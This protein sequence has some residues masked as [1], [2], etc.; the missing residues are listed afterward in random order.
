MKTF[1]LAWITS[2]LLLFD[3]S[4]ISNAQPNNLRFENLSGRRGLPKIGINTIL[5]DQEGFM[6]F[7]TNEGL[8]RFDGHTATVFQHDPNDP[9]HSLPTNL[10]IN[11]HEDRK[12]RFWVA[13]PV[14][15][16]L[17]DKR[18]G[19]ATT[20]RPDSS[21]AF[22][23]NVIN[24]ILE[25][26]EG[27]LWLGT[28]KGIVRF[29][30]STLKFR[31]YSPPSQQ[32]PYGLN[33]DTAG[34]LWSVI[35]G[36]LCR[37]D[38]PT[39]KFD[40]YK[41]K[42]Q[43]GRKSGAFSLYI[44]ATGIAWVGTFG[45]G[46]FRMDTRTPGR[47]VP[48]NPRGI[49]FKI[50]NEIYEADGYLWLASSGLQ[51][52]NPK[53]NEVINYHSDNFQSGT[54]SNSGVYTSYQDRW[55]NLWVG[56]TSGVNK[57]SVRTSPFYT[58]QITPTPDAFIRPEN[59]VHNVLEDRT[60]T[61]WVGNQKG[62]CRFDPSTKQMTQVTVNPADSRNTLE[63]QQWPLLEDRRGRL[64]V[65]TDLDQGLYVLDRTTNKFTR[66]NSKIAIRRL[67]IAP[68][69]TIW[70][71]SPVNGI[72]AFDPAREK[73]TYYPPTD[74]VDGVPL[75]TY[76]SAILVSRSE[77]VWVA[78]L[79]TGLIRLNPKTGKFTQY[80]PNTQM[81]Q[82]GLLN[83]LVAIS[84]YE[85][86]AGI[87]WIG[88]AE[89]GLNRLDPTTNVFTYFTTR[90]GLPSNAINSITGDKRGNLWLGT[91]QGLSR[92]N[93]NNHTCR[94]FDESDGL[95][96]DFFI[97]GSIYHNNGKLFLGTR[98]G[99]VIFR[100]DSIKEI[101]ST[102]AYITA[103]KVGERYIPLSTEEIELSH[104]ENYLSFDFTAVN[105]DSPEKTRYAYQ[106]EGV[107][108]DWVYTGNRRS[109]NYAYL[110][111]GSYTFRVKASTNNKVWNDAEATIKIRIHPPWWQTWWAYS[112]YGLLGISVLFGLIRYN[113][114]RERLKS[115]LKIQRLEA[116]KMHEIDHLKS[117]FFANISHE[118]RTP[119]T[120]ILG[121]LEKFLSRPST[122]DD[123]KSAYRMMQRN[124]QR[125]L[126][127]INQLLDLS[128]LETGSMKLETKPASLA[129]FLKTLVSSFTSLA[130]TRQIQYHFKYFTGNPTVYFD[131]D[132]L[133]KIITNLL[134]NAFKFT[135][136]GGSISISALLLKREHD[137]QAVSR[138]G[139][140]SLTT[141]E[142]KVQDSGL[143][144]PDD[145][146]D[147]IFNRFYQTDTSQ[148]QAK[149]G[150]GIGL[151]LVRELVE[152][153]GGKVM[154]ESQVG[155]GTRFTIHLPLN[156]TDFEETIV[157]HGP[158]DDRNNEER[159]KITFEN[160]SSD[161]NDL[162][163]LATE[164]GSVDEPIILI[165]EDNTD[166]RNF[167]REN[168]HSY[169][170]IEAEE[171]E[172]A[173]KMASETIPDLIISDVMM[174]KMN[175]VE[176]CSKL[177]GNEKTDHI[178]VILL[179]AKASVENKIEGLETG[180][181]DYIVKPF[182]MSELLIRIKNLLES[183][184]KLRE[185][186]SREIT[187]Q[188]ASISITPLDEKLL[189]RVMEIME[190][191]ISD[192][193]FGVELFCQEAA[194]SR[195]QLYRKLKALT[196]QSPSDFIRSMRLKRAAELIIHNAGNIAEVAFQ[197]GFK[198]PSYFT[199]CFQMQFG[200]TPSEFAKTASQRH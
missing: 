20:Y 124:A 145:Q 165:V 66:Y 11:I 63:G 126:H 84:V 195:V 119:L 15:L 73:F 153:H 133:E 105:F 86:E 192:S 89:G 107:D 196:D 64:W 132:K 141:L 114:S 111:P 27:L 44:D 180:A 2:S 193:N 144:I 45:D 71:G 168:L 29:D 127:L 135:S 190:E 93:P 199:K 30:P 10:I 115:D 150:T 81:K 16:L 125:L 32:S 186:F 117:R 164:M 77:E 101:L 148:K 41:I 12:G 34:G 160:D 36:G 122:P 159:N 104:Q 161:L 131:A 37:F 187:L 51:R 6:W 33:Q 185:R 174:P 109:D 151:A 191:H 170:V 90:D 83:D 39:G 40:F 140:P 61:V 169:R 138:E 130:E 128:K 70:L 154:V 95:P 136:A 24:D 102:P 14:G 120:L 103:L 184:K 47:F 57:A 72:A 74:D 23:W 59:A 87:I 52:I 200:K 172:R 146:L 3:I 163:K 50:I 175:G 118:F 143:G 194:M 100:P 26:R 182:E 1:S 56:T 17:L 60:G 13:T 78:S 108:R 21:R 82:E 22:G 198:E 113:V 137:L 149:D 171:G 173:Y 8:Y 156:V 189:R 18:T 96:D 67:S 162:S 139:E 134:S 31:L 155:K 142:I 7:G 147:K 123:D 121:P 176:L 116:E 76:V 129:A 152:L 92:F 79:G 38:P 112:L 166:I 183:R 94:N 65:G 99:L 35:Y 179:T 48:Y 167:I 58:H 19:S 55:D 178:P 97:E 110:S 75:G 43:D 4:G 197:V 69:G 106:L 68:S 25:D 9:K 42:T 54:L 28:G 88:T 181:D 62:L 98:N 85:D 53:T 80:L 157:E 46:L 5:Q 158:I 91:S 177:K 188:P 49:V